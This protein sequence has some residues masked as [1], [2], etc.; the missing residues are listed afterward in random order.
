MFVLLAL[1]VMVTPAMAVTKTWVGTNSNWNTAS[2]WAPSGT[3]NLNNDDIIISSGNPV[4]SGNMTLGSNA[5]LTINSGGSLE[6]TGKMVINGNGQLIINGGS[7]YHSGSQFTFPY[8]S[9]TN[10]IIYSGTFTTE[11]GGFKVNSRM[12]M[13]GGV[14]NCLDG[15]AVQSGKTFQ[16]Y[17]GVI[18]VTG[19]LDIQS[20]NSSFHAG[21]DSLIVNGRMNLG[22]SCN[23]YGDTAIIL[24]NGTGNGNV[25]N[26]LNGN[27]YTNGAT[28]K[29]NPSATTSI[30]SGG[31]FYGN[32]GHV[33][34]NDIATIGNSGVLN[35][36]SATIIFTEDLTVSQSGAINA[37]SGNLT[38]SGDANFQNSGTLDAGSANITIQGDATFTQNGVLNGGS[39][40]LT[41]EGNATF[42]NSGT[43]NA[44]S[45]TVNFGGDVTISNNGGTINAD[46]SS[47]TI[48]GDF[49]NSGSFNAGTSTV[50][51][52]GDSS[53]T[54]TTDVTFYNLNIQTQGT[55]TANGNVTVTGNG[56][57]GS[58]SG[59]S[60]P[61]NNDQFEVNGDL[62]DSSGTL[63]VN[64]SKPFVT[65]ISV[66]DSVTVLITFN[67]QVSQASAENAANTTWTGRTISSRI[68]IDTNKLQLV[69]TPAIVHDVTYTIVF[70]NIQNLRNPVGTMNAGHTKNFTWPSPPNIPTVQA[71]NLNIAGSSDTSISI[72]WLR[73]N[74]D[75][76]M[77]V[78]RQF[79]PVTANP[80]DAVWYAANPHFGTGSSIGQATYCVYR[81]TGSS[82]TVT[83][84]QS[85]REYYFT[86][87]EFNNEGSSPNYLT[88]NKPVLA[89][90]THLRIDIT[91][92]LEGPFDGQ[93]MQP[94]LN[95]YLPDSQ[96]YNRAPWNYNGTEN[97]SA[98]PN[99]SIVDWVLI[100]LRQAPTPNQALDTSIVGRRAAFL[101][102]N[103]KIVDLDGV[104]PVLI[105]T[106]RA[107]RMFVVVHHRTHIPIQSSDSL[108]RQGNIFTYNFNASGSAFGSSPLHDFGNGN[109]G[110][111]C[112][113]ANPNSAG[114]V[115]SSDANAAWTNRNTIGYSDADVNL[116]GIVNAEDRAWIYNN[117]GV[118]SEVVD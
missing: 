109:F 9:I 111:Y 72:S 69:F 61:D 58:N 102:S 17:A 45:S 21:S 53:Q 29:F 67:E 87:F 92:V 80:S 20:S 108:V 107:G 81:G 56:T 118:Q 31:V 7:Y 51:L 12:E 52:N 98:M 41:F 57:I 16:A 38:F 44:S 33:T 89:T 74:G 113:K 105:N 78:V 85:N 106:N 24:I 55:L 110:A 96:V 40:T 76:C 63:A 66:I 34:F 90:N 43:L 100:E 18:H 23:F 70:Q 35:V 13:Y 6:V 103:G 30:G 32:S 101:L 42:S 49:D 117:Q 2:N 91:L 3:P 62:T 112:G 28:I 97:V 11:A 39:S 114:G 37:G 77:V 25:T 116:D 88:S 64:T 84:L 50:T 82:V 5:S 26:N 27:F 8:S 47:I 60:I 99:D 115:G 71:N 93:R 19:L 22:S 65:G 83:G 59:I 10:V 48:S 14:L 68:L 4:Y 15:L 75:S 46:S 36:D 73:G 104:S 86:V 94:S 54:I 1:L 95:A 79:A